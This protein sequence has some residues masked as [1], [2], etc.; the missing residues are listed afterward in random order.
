MY[1]KIYFNDKPLL[2]TTGIDDEIRSYLQG[3]DA[4]NFDFTQPDIIATVI[5]TMQK[6]AVTAGVI[7]HKNIDAVLNAFKSELVL[8][9]AAGGYIYF[10]NNLLLIFRRGKWDLPK[11]KVD[12]GENLEDAALREVKEETGL[13]KATLK[14]LLCITYHTYYQGKDFILKESHW[15]LMQAQEMEELIPQTEEDITKCE[16]VNRNNLDDYLKNT[17]PSI[18]DV[19]HYGLAKKTE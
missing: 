14:G 12:E 19:I 18:A 11:G 13:E 15:Y 6:P 3:K 10:E 17:H 2:I 7:V 1:K 5:A 9:Q 4:E 16:W 8:I